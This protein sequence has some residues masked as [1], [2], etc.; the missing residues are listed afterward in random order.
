MVTTSTTSHFARPH[1][2][3]YAR[4]Q[5]WGLVT[6]SGGIVGERSVD[7]AHDGLVERARVGKIKH[8]RV[9]LHHG[10]DLREGAGGRGQERSGVAAVHQVRTGGRVGE[11]VLP[12]HASAPTARGYSHKSCARSRAIKGD[13]RTKR[14]TWVTSRAAH[15]PR[16]RHRARARE[17][18]RERGWGRDRRAPLSQ[19]NPC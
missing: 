13:T 9:L 16:K 4:Q 17:R 11:C 18:E 7:D 14:S 6:S 10:L 2:K 5:R 1:L 15:A 12:T 19:R 8:H 3:V